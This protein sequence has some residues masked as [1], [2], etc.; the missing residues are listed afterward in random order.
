MIAFAL[1]YTQ[2]MKNNI[3][4]DIL[5]ERFP[6]KVHRMLD[7]TN[8]FVTMIFFGIISWQIFKWGMKVWESHELSET[9]KVIY[10]PFVFCV[11][12]GFAVL[13]LTLLVDFL[14]TILAKEEK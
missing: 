4:V 3:V 5:T 9:L 1:G 7:M 14:Q 13:S 8:Y 11:S 12:I 10:H 6:K 2:K